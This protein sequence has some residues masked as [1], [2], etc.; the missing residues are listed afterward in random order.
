MAEDGI[1]D[2]GF[3]KRKA[4]R[5]LG[6]TDIQN[7]PSNTEI[8]QALREY[9]A[10]FQRDEQARRLREL[11]FQAVRVMRE[12]APFD[13]HLSGPVLTGTAARYSAI[14]I[15]I[16]TDNPKELDLFW[17]NRN[18]VGKINEREYRFNDRAHVVPVKSLNWHGEA[19]V[20]I[21]IFST[22]DL[23]QIPL[24]SADGKDLEKSRLSAVEALLDTNIVIP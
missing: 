23:K 9:Q 8:E 1:D 2:F 12:L 20:N 17:V 18:L 3:A 21:A 6:A 16:F 13:P 7:L 11:R 5:Q 15:M 19:E 4:A 14:E 10:L 24:R 22:A